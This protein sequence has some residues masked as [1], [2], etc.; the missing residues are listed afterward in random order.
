MNST[1]AIIR[2]LEAALSP[3]DLDWVRG[4][5]PYRFGAG[6]LRAPAPRRGGPRA[7]RLCEFGEGATMAHVMHRAGAFPSVSQA[8]KNGW[9][10]PIEPGEWRVGRLVV[11]IT[12]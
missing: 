5:G 10:R 3:A 4:T 7:F 1:A 8:R 11:E 6:D 2:R 9:N 12:P